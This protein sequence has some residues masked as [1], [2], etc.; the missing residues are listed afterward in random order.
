MSLPEFRVSGRSRNFRSG[1]FVDQFKAAFEKAKPKLAI[2]LR[3]NIASL[4][5]SLQQ[6]FDD[7][8]DNRGI[9]AILTGRGTVRTHKPVTIGQ[10]TNPF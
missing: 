9:A 3:P 8:I 6:T 1:I 4:W 10:K 5:K 7:R 2:I